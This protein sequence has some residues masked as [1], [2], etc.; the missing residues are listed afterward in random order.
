MQ[1]HK[2]FDFFMINLETFLSGNRKFHGLCVI[3]STITVMC[4]CLFCV[5]LSF[6]NDFN[7]VLRS[8]RNACH[9]SEKLQCT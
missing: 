2:T 7:A 5:K 3:P 1:I 6:E 9:E 8:L 4:I